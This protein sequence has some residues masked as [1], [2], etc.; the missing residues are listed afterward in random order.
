MLA[1]AKLPHKFWAETL[2]TAVYLR[3]RSPSVAVKGK[4][5]FEAWTGQKPNVKHLRVFGCEAYAHVPKD[6]RK[7]PDSKARKRIL[8]GYGTETKGYRL[9]N[10]NRARVFHSRDVQVNESSQEPGAVKVQEPKQ[11]T[12]S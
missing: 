11:N 1:D 3:N 10:P 12:L 4:T 8:L 5:P 9:Y 7:K 6:E 2:S